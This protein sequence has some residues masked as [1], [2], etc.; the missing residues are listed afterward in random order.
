MP[1]CPI[2]KKE[3][4][5]VGPKLLVDTREA[6]VSDRRG[7]DRYQTTVM[8]NDCLEKYKAGDLRLGN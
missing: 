2:C 6:N 1:I 5:S 7:A 4:I 3:S 8:C